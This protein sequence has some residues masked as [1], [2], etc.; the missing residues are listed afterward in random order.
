MNWFKALPTLWK[1]I[2]AVLAVIA[3]IWALAFVY[4]LLFGSKDVEGKLGTNQAGA[5]IESGT[6]AVETV[7]NQQGNESQIKGDVEETQNAVDEANDSAG[8]DAAGRDGLCQHF[9]VG[10]EE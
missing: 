1:A 8:A 9:G 4:G 6:D 7:G 2:T 3:A 5:A 10:C